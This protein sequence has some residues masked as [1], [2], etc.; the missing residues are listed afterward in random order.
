MEDLLDII[1]NYIISCGIT[2]VVTVVQ[3][4]WSI[5]PYGESY[6]SGA[7]HIN[8]AQF[9]GWVSQL[10]VNKLVHLFKAANVNDFEFI[11]KFAINYI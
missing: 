11:D 4:N 6:V 3:G 9:F 5:K 2:K 7:T 8:N 1:Y 10:D